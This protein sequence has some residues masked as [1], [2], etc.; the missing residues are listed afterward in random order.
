MNKQINGSYGVHPR[1][2]SCM[3]SEWSESQQV[4]WMQAD[5]S[6]TGLS[7]AGWE[8]EIR[9]MATGCTANTLLS[10]SLCG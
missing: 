8:A 7:P 4:V 5:P 10:R 9:F 6:R 2:V 1:I 3:S